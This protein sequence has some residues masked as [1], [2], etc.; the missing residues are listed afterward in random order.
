MHTVNLAMILCGKIMTIAFSFFQAA[1][2]GLAPTQ[3]FSQAPTQDF[4]QSNP[5]GASP[6]SVSPAGGVQGARV[7]VWIVPG[8]RYNRKE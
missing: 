4:S 2:R 3:D 6:L 5:V 7:S 1:V 8:Q